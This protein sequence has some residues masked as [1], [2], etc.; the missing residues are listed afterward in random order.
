[1]PVPPWAFIRKLYEK[2]LLGW[3]AQTLTLLTHAKAELEAARHSLA[4]LQQSTDV[5]QLDAYWTAFL[6]HLER[7]WFKAQAELKKLSKWQ[8]WSENGRTISFGR[9]LARRRE[10]MAWGALAD[11]LDQQETSLRINSIRP[12]EADNPGNLTPDFKIPGLFR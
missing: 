2:R 1:M 7:C 12:I 11:L 6:R 9:V 8:G 5:G 4:Q 3:S 10:V